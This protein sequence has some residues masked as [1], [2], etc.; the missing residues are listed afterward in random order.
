MQSEN[1][2]NC[3]AEV[4]FRSPALPARICDYCHATVKRIADGV[5][6]AGEVA[7]LPF[8]VSPIQIGT[9]G[10]YG[11]KHF[12]VIGRIRL[13]Y[14]QGAWND[15]LCLFSDNTHGWLSESDG[16]FQMVVERPLSEIRSK[17]IRR[18]A[19]GERVEVGDRTQIDGAEFVVADARKARCVAAEGELPFAPETGWEVFNVD[20]RDF[21]GFSANFE[22]EEGEEP[23]FY[24]GRYVTLAELNP[25]NLRSI[26]GWKMPDYA[27]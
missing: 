19:N 13:A 5:E 2:P 25:K 26:H 11:G 16:Q 27:A 20:L 12:E 15:W 18:L 21:E 10:E 1:C 23:A 24:M 9:R 22:H 8:D 3:G 4:I 7:V 6:L 14:D 17:L